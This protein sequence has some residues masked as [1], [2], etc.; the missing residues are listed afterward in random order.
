MSEKDL[1]VLLN[2]LDSANKIKAYVKNIKNA[3]KFFEDEKTF[4][5][6]MMNFIIMGESVTKLSNVF[7]SKN[8]NIPWNKVKDFRNL[9]AHDYFGIDAEEVWQIIKKHLPKLVIDLKKIK[10]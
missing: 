6:V 10:K 9:I 4:D 7:K 8:K 3:D 5:A 1:P 2:I